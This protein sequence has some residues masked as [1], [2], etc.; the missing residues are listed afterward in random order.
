MISPTFAT[1]VVLSFLL[2][3][4]LLI[5]VLNRVCPKYVSYRWSVVVVILALLIGVVID[6]GE[7]SDETRR[8]LIIG[9]LIIA[10]GYVAL[11]TLEKAL[12]NGWLSG[13]RLQAKKGDA[14]VT[15]SASDPGKNVQK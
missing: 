7:L 11:R 10:G 8:S 4:G 12:A 2:V 6:F 1:V 13:I 15:L 5:P 9:G 14:S 3:F